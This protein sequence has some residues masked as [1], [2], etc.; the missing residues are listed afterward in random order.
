[1]MTPTLAQWLTGRDTGASSKAIA[2]FMMGA[3]GVY[4]P[5]PLDPSDFGRC[6]RLMQLIPEFRT[7]LW[8]MR[9]VSPQWTAL[10]DHWEELEAL[11]EEELPF[12][13]A[14]KLYARMKELI[15]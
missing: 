8:M 1:M 7:N 5:H 2:Y 11:Y 6:Y 12:D 9:G 3:R 10:I 15:D 14:P 13:R 4:C